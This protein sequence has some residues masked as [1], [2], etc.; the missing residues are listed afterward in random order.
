MKKALLL[1]AILVTAC[2]GTSAQEPTDISIHGMIGKV[3]RVDER[4]AT[5]VEKKGVAKEEKGGIETT[6]IFDENGRLSRE[7]FSGS[8][9]S[10]RRFIYEKDGVRKS[11]T[12]TT[13]PFEKPNVLKMPG[14]SVSVFKYD[15]KENSISEDRFHGKI[16]SGPILETGDPGN[17]YKYF[18]DAENRLTKEVLMEPDGR[19]ILIEEYFYR[20]SGPTASDIVVS[21][22]GRA[23]QFVKCTYEAD[24]HG[25]WTKRTEARKPVDPKQS[26]VTEITYRKITYYKD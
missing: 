10:E 6:R 17:K 4:I 3:K 5:L 2:F 18:F 19:E 24:S 9:N 23:I 8:S 26:T 20:G 25:N 15:S 1:F 12:D 22:R 7:L 13:Q 14:Y 16:Q 21:S 11:V